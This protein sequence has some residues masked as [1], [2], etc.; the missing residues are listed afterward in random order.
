[1]TYPPSRTLLAWLAALFFVGTAWG[2]GADDFVPG[3]AI[4]TYRPAATR[5]SAEVTAARH[6]A[7]MKRH[8][9]WLSA[10]RNRVTELVQSDTL[11]TAELIAALQK[12]P[13]VLFAEPNYLRQVSRFTTPDD[14]SFPQLWGLENNGQTVD[15]TSGISGDDIGFIP[16]WKLARPSSPEVVVA[17]IDTGL[18]TTHPD[19]V[20]NL[21]TNPGETANNGQDDDANGYVD[22]L[23]GYNFVDRN[24]NIADSGVHGTHVSGT[25]AATGNNA[26]GV[27]GANF[28][29]RIM[30]LKVSK[31]GKN[32]SS[33]GV[34]A[35]LDYVS[36][37]KARGVNI[38]AINASF[39]GESLSQTESAAIAAAG[40][41][42]IVFCAAAGN[43]STD[44]DQTPTY[45]ASYRLPSMIVV[46]ASTQ[47]DTLAG[48]SNRGATSVDLAAPGENIYSLKPTWLATTAPSIVAAG[49]AISG[50]QLQYAATTSGIT[51]QL[52]DCGDGN[53]PAAFP[54]TV[55]G[56]V[57][58]IERGV[59]TF[60][61]K[62][63]NAGNAGAVAAI[64]RD[65]VAPTSGGITLS[66]PADWV[67]AVFVSQATGVDLLAAVGTPVTVIN[68]V[69]AGSIYQF[70][71]GTSM[72]TPQ[73]TAA[74]AFAAQNFPAES[75]VQRVARI[76]NHTRPVAA[77][78]GLV[79]TGGRLDLL[80]IIDTD[81][82]GL[83]DWWEI[84]RLGT[85]ATTPNAD[86]DGDGFTNLQEYLAGTDPANPASRFAIAATTVDPN[87]I[88]AL[89]FPGFPGISYQAEYTDNLSTG[90]WL[91]L[92]AEIEGTGATLTI[93]DPS[94][95]KPPKRFYRLKIL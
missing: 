5:S 25:L 35:A 53:S 1:M 19:I 77:L 90:L 59:G 72:A 2:N 42:G 57:A 75:A 8:F 15:G 29:A 80:K 70:L 45:P 48:F 22:D 86:P 36:M 28:K 66:A 10:R 95:A 69:P 60:V 46:A 52:V 51:G 89:S 92:G 34:I 41:A 68:S 76:L 23:H 4:V 43:K 78:A 56:N 79:K 31:N 40:D 62:L 73:V 67:P 26:L 71:D 54:P 85:L 81:A 7:R 55:A 30:M 44:N 50:F 6:G 49:N 16:A 94:P 63:T 83:P 9:P 88:F 82:D 11:T 84:E 61:A 47:S 21:W 20:A 33:A 37:M 27:I 38:V 3:E 93:A 24:A 91:P 39:G 65:N 64:V 14:P 18:D 17:V 13:D 58:L 12:E 74:V 87:G 32:I